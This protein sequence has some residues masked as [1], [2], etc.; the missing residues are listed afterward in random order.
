MT[1]IPQTLNQLFFSAVD[2]FSTKRAAFRHKAAGAWHDLTHQHFAQRVRHTAMGL[3]ELGIRPGDR[4]AILS[5]NRPEWAIADFG[6]L[7]ARCPDVAIYPTLPARQVAYILRDC[8]AVA[9]FVAD[10]EQYAKVAEC[11]GELPDLQH[12]ILFE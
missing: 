2:R 6:C 12:V 8:G 3:W 4:V 10:P 7:T 1:D 11:R 5:G 9:V